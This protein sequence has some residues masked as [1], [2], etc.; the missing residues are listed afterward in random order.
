M[1]PPTVL[2]GSTVGYPSN[3]LASCLLQSSIKLKLCNICILPIFLYGSE[4][5]AVTRRDVLQIDAW[6]KLL[7]IKWY[8]HVWNDEMR[9][10]TKPLSAIVQTRPGG[11][12]STAPPPFRLGD[13]ALCGSPSHPI[14]GDLLCFFVYQCSYCIFVLFLY[15]FWFLQYFDTVGWVFWPVNRLPDNL[16]CVGGDVKPCS[17]NHSVQARPFLPV[18][19]HCTNARRNRC[20]KDLNRCPLENWRR[21]PGRPCTM[22]TTE[23]EIQSPLPE[24]SKWRGYESSTLE[25]DVYVQLYTLLVV[26]ARNDDDLL[27][28]LYKV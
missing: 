7:G 6:W 20:Q 18:Q 2:W 21:P 10:T 28:L 11:T 17:I 3:S 26:H 24:W 19:P 12:V 16:Y 15:F 14:L 1:W 8:H 4:C 27:L 13:P 5:W 25:T 9:W 23:P 22:W